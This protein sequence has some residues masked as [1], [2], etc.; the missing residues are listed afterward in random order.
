MK[1]RWL[2]VSIVPVSTLDKPVVAGCL[3]KDFIYAL[4]D[5]FIVAFSMCGIFVG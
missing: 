5:C 4:F 1:G 2:R 3:D